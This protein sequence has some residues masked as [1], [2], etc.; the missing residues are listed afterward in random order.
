MTIV[1]DTTDEIVI[2][3]A[4][5][6]PAD[7]PERIADLARTVEVTMPDFQAVAKSTFDMLTERD[8]MCRNADGEW[9]GE[10]TERFDELTGFGHLQKLLLQVYAYAGVAT[11]ETPSQTS[12]DPWTWYQ[13]VRAAER[14][15]VD[16]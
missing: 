4:I 11:G 2:Q 16:G 5:S 10:L 12:G 6:V 1:L 3:P 8:I 13:A 7:L 14:E 15:E 9:S